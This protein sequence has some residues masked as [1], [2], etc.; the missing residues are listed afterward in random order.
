MSDEVIC[1]ECHEPCSVRAED[2][3]IGYYEYGGAV[4]YDSRP[5]PVSACCDAEL[6]EADLPEPDFEEPDRFYYEEY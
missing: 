3:G 5:F 2:N 4:G 1:P 6:D